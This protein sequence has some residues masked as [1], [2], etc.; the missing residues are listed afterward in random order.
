MTRSHL[1]TQPRHIIVE[2]HSWS[3]KK[4]S[5]GSL[6]AYVEILEP[7]GY[8]LL[9]VAWVDAVFGKIEIANELRL[10]MLKVEAHGVGIV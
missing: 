9:T 2:F 4:S 7:L 1:K 6:A 5:Q 3:P 8:E 10:T